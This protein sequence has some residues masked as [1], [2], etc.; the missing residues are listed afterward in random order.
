LLHIRKAF[1]QVDRP[2]A[3]A[4]LAMTGGCSVGDAVEAPEVACSARDRAPAPAI[5]S[6]A[7]RRLICRGCYFIYVDAR[8]LPAQSI[9]PGTPFAEIS[10]HW[11][12]PDCG[13]DKTNFRP[14]VAKAAG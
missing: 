8:G 5:A 11:K 14:Y 13:T 2:E 1:I 9:A 12:C 6:G 4:E 10:G 7:Q 3:G